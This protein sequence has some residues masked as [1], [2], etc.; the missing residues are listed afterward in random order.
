MPCRECWLPHQ[1]LFPR[2]YFLQRQGYPSLLLS[3][4]PPFNTKLLWHFSSGGLHP[5]N[6][7]LST[8]ISWSL[9]INP[10][11][12]TKGLSKHPWKEW[13][14]LKSKTSKDFSGN[15]ILWMHRVFAWTKLGKGQGRG[16]WE[17]S[18][19]CSSLYL[20]KNNEIQKF[21][22]TAAHKVSTQPWEIQT[23]SVLEPVMDLAWIY[24]CFPVTVPSERTNPGAVTARTQHCGSSAEGNTAFTR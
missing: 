12:R 8:E 3:L 15:Y 5:P 7:R 1:L 23:A 2:R 13:T 17:S 4:L 24:L 14:C 16:R 6:R 9:L 11:N 10:E 20:K 18:R 22:T 19:G 21:G